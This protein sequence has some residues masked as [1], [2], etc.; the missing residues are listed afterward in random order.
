MDE[1]KKETEN[2]NSAD[3]RVELIRPVN[4]CSARANKVFTSTN[5][6]SSPY[7]VEKNAY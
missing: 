2:Q 4:I 7:T 3:W 1:R 6:T 5:M